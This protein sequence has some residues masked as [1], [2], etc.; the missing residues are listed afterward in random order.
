MN[1]N[2]IYLIGVPKSF[3][4]AIRNNILSTLKNIR[5]GLHYTKQINVVVFDAPKEMVI[6]EIGMTGSAIGKS[7]IQILIDFK[8]KFTIQKFTAELSSSVAH[9]A[10]HLVRED[11]LEYNRSLLDAMVNEGV[12]CYIEKVFFP[13]HN[14]PYIAAIKNEK[15][16]IKKAHIE[17]YKK[18]YDNSRWFFGSEKFPRWIGY[19]I[20]FLIVSGC[21]QN[22]KVS[23]AKLTRM[24]SVEILK[25]S[26]II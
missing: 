4:K 22:K 3:E 16:F 21:I 20:G 18:H 8:R 1:K 11:V 12:A 17:F 14:I 5:R 25:G 13:R 15:N 6:P 9:E 23:L 7:G 19:R 2:L 24:K 10:A 26:K